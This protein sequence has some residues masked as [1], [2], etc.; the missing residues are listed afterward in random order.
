VKSITFY[1]AV[2]VA[3]N[4]AASLKEMAQMIDVKTF[5]EICKAVVMLTFFFLITDFAKKDSRR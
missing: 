1:S 5:D 4:A 3:R 2:R